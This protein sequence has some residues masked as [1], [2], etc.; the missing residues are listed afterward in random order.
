MLSADGGVISPMVGTW[1]SGRLIVGIEGGSGDGS[2]TLIVGTGG[3]EAWDAEDDLRDVLPRSGL[4]LFG[5][6]SLGCQDGS[7]L[8][9]GRPGLSLTAVGIGSLLLRSFNFMLV[10]ARISSLRISRPFLVGT[11]SCVFKSVGGGGLVVYSG[12]RD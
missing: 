9:I 8:T 10:A 11:L 7:K 2:D 12:F 6:S 3:V 5:F 1:S 4:L